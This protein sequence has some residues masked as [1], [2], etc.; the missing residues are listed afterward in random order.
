M[1]SADDRRERVLGAPGDQQHG[2]QERRGEQRRDGRRCLRVGIGKPVVHRRPADLGGESG[3]QEQVGDERGLGRACVIGSACQE[4][5]PRPPPG[6]PAASMT[7]PISAMPRPSEVRMRYF[8]PASSARAFPLKPTSSA[9]A[10]VVASIRSQAA[11]RFPASGTRG[12]PSRTRRAR[13]SRPLCR[14]AAETS[15]VR[16]GR[17]KRGRDEHAGEAHHG[18]DADQKAAGGVDRDAFSATGSPGSPSASAASASAR[19][20]D[21]NAPPK[22]TAVTRRRGTSEMITAVSAGAASTVQASVSRLITQAPQ[23]RAVSRAELGED[24]LVEHGRDEHDQREVERHTELDQR[25]RSREA[26][27]RRA[28]GRSRRVRWP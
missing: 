10:A 15:E 5:A 20:A 2:W 7:M 21:G 13:R 6:T 3:E 18:D 19:A 27:A 1:R 11:P 28:P 16:D 22:A 26:R 24:P 12:A 14:R 8:Q 9:E 25:R 17:Q 4:S 23:R